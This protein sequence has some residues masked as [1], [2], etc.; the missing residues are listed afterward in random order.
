MASGSGVGCGAPIWRGREAALVPGSQAGRRASGGGAASRGSGAASREV[1]S[2]KVLAEGPR[3]P[4][5]EWWRE[6]AE[7]RQ[8]RHGG[9]GAAAGEPRWE[10]R[11]VGAHRGGGGGLAHRRPGC[12]EPRPQPRPRPSSL[13]SPCPSPPPHTSLRMA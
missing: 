11:A 9:G 1:S 10:S 5:P 6:G 7:R 2:L 12:P 3:L 8:R 13:S 4:E